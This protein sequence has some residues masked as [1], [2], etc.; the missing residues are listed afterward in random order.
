ML[1][2][3]D[4]LR[5]AYVQQS[6]NEIFQKDYIQRNML[7]ARGANKKKLQPRE[8]TSDIE[9]HCS[10][11]FGLNQPP[12]LQQILAV[13]ITVDAF[14]VLRVFSMH[15]CQSELLFKIQLKWTEDQ[16]YAVACDIYLCTKSIFVCS[17][18][19]QNIVVTKELKQFSLFGDKKLQISKMLFF[20][21]KGVE[22]LALGFRSGVGIIK[23]S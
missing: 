16:D 7:G 4:E 20:E 21:I 17:K 10:L 2:F 11:S 23:N 18:L 15:A 22:M 1:F 13:L 12:I 3:L 6:L 19:G 8:L 14:N 5:L 9:V